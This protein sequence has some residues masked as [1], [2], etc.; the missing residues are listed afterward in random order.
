[1]QK[2]RNLTLAVLIF[3]VLLSVYKHRD[4]WLGQL[5]DEL[6]SL[7]GR[8]VTLHTVT[9]PDVAYAS[10]QGPVSYA[11]AVRAAAPA[12]VSIY[13]KQTTRLTNPWSNDPFFQRFYGPQDQGSEQ[14]QSL[15]SGLIVSP[16]GY[17]LTNN[18]VVSGAD[19]IVVALADGRETQAQI[20]GTDPD[21]DIAVL[22]IRMSN[23]PVANLRLDSTLQVGDVVLAIGNPFGIG[24]TV[25]QGIVSALG[26]QGLGLNTYE[27]FI[28]TDAA[29][30]PG[31]SGGA[32]IDALGNV[33]GINSAIYSR[34]GGN[35]GIGFA[36]PISLAKDIM[37][38]LIKNGHVVRGWLGI[39]LAAPS[40]SPL[41]A[42][43]PQQPVQI[44]SVLRGGPADQAGLLPGDQI[45]SI[46]QQPLASIQQAMHTIAAFK[47]G[48]HVVFSIRR[49]HD[50][51]D[52]SAI[53]GERPAPSEQ[54]QP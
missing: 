20:V 9:A 29:I 41:E 10:R 21:T 7:P 54:P 17:I 33:I 13:T 53:I 4:H 31:N 48:S 52:R 43:S 30:N 38:D 40:T 3:F 49:D 36:I 45:V 11:Q 39:E 1:M 25:T 46:N 44:N 42:S 12:V 37:T 24:Q 6:P 19:S 26:R 23:L 22:H 50:T 32:L 51:L 2:L 28:Q 8:T 14:H 15:G 16:D 35:M 18:H 47:P 34:S 5:G 27:D